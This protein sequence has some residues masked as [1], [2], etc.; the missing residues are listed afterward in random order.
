MKTARLSTLA[1]LGRVVALMLADMICV[2]VMWFVAVLGY[3]WLGGAH[4]DPVDYLQFWPV[5]VFFVWINS[6]VRLY[7]GHCIYPSVP[8]NEVE[9]FRRLFCS[10][11]VTH[12]VAM[13]FLGFSRHVD[14]LSRVVLVISGLGIAIF[15]Q[16]FRNAVR[17]IL[18]RLDIA[19]IP[20]FI[21]GSGEIA[22]LIS[23]VCAT[24]DALGYRIVGSFDSKGRELKGVPRLGGLRDIVA[25][26]RE[27]RVN[28]VVVCEDVRI[29]EE[30]MIDF[31]EHFQFIDYFPTN[32]TFPVSGSR[33]I[34]ARGLGGVELV[35]QTCMKELGWEKRAMDTFFACV[36]MVLFSPLFL[37]IAAAVKLTSKGPVFYRHERLGSD[38][39]SI[40]VWKFR[41]MYVDADERLG[42]ILASDPKAKA[43]WE[44]N[45]KLKDD[46]RITPVGRFL[47]RSSLDELPQLFNVFAGTM[48]VVGPR[49]IVGEEVQYYGDKY[50]LFS[51]VR[52]GI[53]GLWQ[54]SGRSDTDYPHRVA[55]DCYYVLNWSPWMD[56]WV[57]LRTVYAV[58]SMR[59]A[60]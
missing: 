23:S 46:P 32:R 55:L 12:L 47:R 42:E 16:S 60:C 7:H 21:V 48:A 9:E 51:R 56:I 57:I 35:N 53:T 5:G 26:G 54:V 49:P 17:R 36:A 52:P 11:I 15:A 2:C 18:K 44:A 13:A 58:F 22:Q 14:V 38:G 33:T 6:V 43:E 1:G 25:A 41:S 28:R 50:R 30:L 37:V 3:K 59:G 20:V 31:T 34:S 4:Y 8:L 10:A 39:K 40:K 29:L 27:M 45:F 19:Q 24:D